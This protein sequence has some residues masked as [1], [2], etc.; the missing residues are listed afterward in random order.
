MFNRRKRHEPTIEEQYPAEFDSDV[1]ENLAFNKAGKLSPRQR[2]WIL[3]QE[4]LL[5]PDEIQTLY[6]N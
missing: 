1:V 6:K 5:K 4:M 3:S 2:K